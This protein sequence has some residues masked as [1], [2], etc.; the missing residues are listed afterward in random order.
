MKV[1]VLFSGRDEIEDIYS[2]K[3][4]TEKKAAEIMNGFSTMKDSWWKK[5]VDE[6]NKKMWSWF[7]KSQK[8]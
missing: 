5:E 1:W 2:S 6:E 3:T 7:Y 8:G 4:K